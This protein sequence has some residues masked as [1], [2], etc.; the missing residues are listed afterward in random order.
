MGRKRRI[1]LISIC[2]VCL[3]LCSCQ[4]EILSY[5]FDRYPG[6]TEITWDS[7]DTM[8]LVTH[9]ISGDEFSDWGLIFSSS[10]EE[11]CVAMI[12][13]YSGSDSTFLGL[14]TGSSCANANRLEVE[15]DTP[16]KG[17][18]IEF[19]GSYAKYAMDVLDSEG[20]M[21]DSPVVLCNGNTAGNLTLLEYT[22]K[23][24]DI[25]RIRFGNVV[26]IPFTAVNIYE[27]KLTR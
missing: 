9:N 4:T 2:T 7:S 5:T 16:V 6:G 10:P 24:N 23:T 22:S 17:V 11:D 18:S 19:Y 25:K 27:L 12:T 1:L 15:F 13:G 21:L 26:S 8:G 14:L 20:K 3:L